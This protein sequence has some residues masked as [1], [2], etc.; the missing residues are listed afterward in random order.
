VGGGICAVARESG[1]GR[2]GEVLNGEKELR[3]LGS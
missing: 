2:D 3:G 1:E